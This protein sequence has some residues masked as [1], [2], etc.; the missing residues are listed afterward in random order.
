MTRV[1]GLNITAEPP[2]SAPVSESL[3]GVELV[4]SLFVGFVV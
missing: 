2:D 3:V 4:V 1:E